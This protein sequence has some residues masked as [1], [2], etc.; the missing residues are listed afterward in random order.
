MHI[1]KRRGHCTSSLQAG[2]LLFVAVGTRKFDVMVM[3][4]GLYML[5]TLDRVADDCAVHA[6][7]QWRVQERLCYNTRSI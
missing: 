1:Q 4:R 3:R 2:T 6:D 7:Q 5:P